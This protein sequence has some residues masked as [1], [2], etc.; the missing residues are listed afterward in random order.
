MTQPN[1]CMIGTYAG[2]YPGGM[3]TLASILEAASI[4]YGPDIRFKDF[5]DF[6]DVEDTSRRGLGYSMATWE[7]QGLDDIQRYALRAYC[8]A[9]SAQVYV[10][11][12]TNETTSAGIH[13]W[14]TYLATMLWVT[15][16]EDREVWLKDVQGG[17]MLGAKFEFRALVAQD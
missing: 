3:V 16:Y 4:P 2:G 5:S 9:L 13:V 8:S 7:W 11:T 10:R 6:K 12:A 1:E 17:Y 15:E 14:H